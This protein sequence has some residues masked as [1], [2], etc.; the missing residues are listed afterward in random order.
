MMNICKIFIITLC[1]FAV[2]ASFAAA[3]QIAVLNEE[4]LPDR[5][6]Y[7]ASQFESLQDAKEYKIDLINDILSYTS[8]DII[9]YDE[10][11]KISKIEKKDGISI[12]YTYNYNDEGEI[13]SINF[14]SYNSNQELNF[15]GVITEGGITIEDVGGKD[16]PGEAKTGPQLIVKTEKIDLEDNNTMVEFSKVDFT[17]LKEA[18]DSLESDYETA[19][20]EKAEFES[21]SGTQVKD[22]NAAESLKEAAQNVPAVV[23]VDP[24]NSTVDEIKIERTMDAITVYDARLRDIKAS[25]IDKINDILRDKSGLIFVKDDIKIDALI[26]LPVLRDKKE[27]KEE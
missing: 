2:C 7:S 11:G 12:E 23:A 26:K 24:K 3:E 4:A 16:E 15:T 6:S 14:C 8:D 21:R 1:V 19:L 18:F 13:E 9:T 22:D 27:K 10:S 5:P 17:L 25:F 20:K